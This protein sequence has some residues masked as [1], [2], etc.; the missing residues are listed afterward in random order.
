MNCTDPYHAEIEFFGGR[1][2]LNK[3]P[4]EGADIER[5]EMVAVKQIFWTC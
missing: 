3:L 4:Y 5:R 2:V 1:G